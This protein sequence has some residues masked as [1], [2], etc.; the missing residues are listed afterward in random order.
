[1]KKILVTGSS[2]YIGQHVCAWLAKKH[3]ITGVDRIVDGT[4]CHKFIHQD[5]L[6]TN[7]IPGE[8]DAVVHLAALVQVG[9]GEKCMMD[10]YRTNVVGTMNILERVEYKNFIFAS[11]CQ[12]YAKHVYGATKLAGERIVRKY[13]E[14]ND[15]ASTIF[16]FGNVVGSGGYHFTNTDGLMYNLQKAK[17]TGVFYLYGD[18]YQ[19][20]DGSA[21]RDY[22]HVLEVCTAIDKAIDR[23]SCVPGAEIQPDYE[24]LG[25]G[26][27]YTVKQCIEAFKKVNDCDFDVIVKPRRVGDP[28]SFL[29]VSL[30]SPYMP[31]NV[32]TL[33]GMMKL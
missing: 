29:E 20:S 30:I 14:L 13:C 9:M 33:E 25:H 27:E 12:V 7:Q 19:T 16:R 3:H 8:Y 6:D 28:N 21:E 4:G 22:L 1:M 31:M 5:I 26:K 15:K 23:P 24:Y 11:T 18:D 17:E 10:Y 2:G 32:F